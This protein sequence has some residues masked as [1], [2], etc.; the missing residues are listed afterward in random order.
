[1]QIIFTTL[2]YWKAIASETRRIKY[3]FAKTII[4]KDTAQESRY[5]PYATFS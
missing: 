2:L 5:H 4:R 1:M 3:I